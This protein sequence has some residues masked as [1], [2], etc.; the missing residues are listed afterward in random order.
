MCRKENMQRETESPVQ[1]RDPT[2][3]SHITCTGC[4][5]DLFSLLTDERCPECGEPIRDSLGPD[6][7][8]LVRAGDIVH[9]VMVAI[10]WLALVIA[11]ASWPRTT[12]WGLKK[13]TCAAVVDTCAIAGALLTGHGLLIILWLGRQRSSWLVKVTTSASAALSVFWLFFFA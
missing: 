12:H 2:V 8:N 7:G 5:Y 4:G 6:R 1:K 13:M 9:A 3:R 10:C 11:F